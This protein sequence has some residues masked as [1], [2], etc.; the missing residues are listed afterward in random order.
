MKI[1]PILSSYAK[2]AVD[3]A[4]KCAQASNIDEYERLDRHIRRL[5]GMAREA[6]Q[7]EFK[8]QYEAIAGHLE[9]GKPLTE[10]EKNALELLIVGEAQYY[11]QDEANFEAW[12]RELQQLMQEIRSL[13][14]QGL[15]QAD[16]LL[17]LQALCRDLRGILPDMTMYL[18]ERDRIQSFQRS[19][20]ASFDPETARVLA[21]VIRAMLSSEEM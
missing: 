20:Q 19:V 12:Q 7:E 4:D 10:E 2:A 5:E 6:F 1:V 18:R 16:T 21:D 13:E 17:R 15:D 3:L 14:S 11:I 9:E 8:A